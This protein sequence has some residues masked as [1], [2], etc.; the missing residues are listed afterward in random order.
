MASVTR[1]SHCGRADAPRTVV[2]RAT[3]AL[4]P[5]N[6]L[7]L[8]PR[9]TPALCPVYPLTAGS[10]WGEQGQYV[11]PP[12]GGS[13]ASGEAGRS[14][15]SPFITANPLWGVAVTRVALGWA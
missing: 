6:L 11:R 9:C 4:L 7:L 15:P 13:R 2:R 12:R 5:R 1:P 10:G 3:Q 14:R 8:C